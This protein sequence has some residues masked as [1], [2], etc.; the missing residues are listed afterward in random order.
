MS[1]I[2]DKIEVTLN[3]KKYQAKMDFYCLANAQ[4]YFKQEKNVFLTVPQMIEGISKDDLSVMGEILIQAIL[5]VHT[6][7]SRETIQEQMKFNELNIIRQAL[8]DLVTASLPQS[9]DKKKV[10]E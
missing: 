1:L 7:L 3:G 4:W 8:G 2:N 5:R 10:E 9:D 6:Q